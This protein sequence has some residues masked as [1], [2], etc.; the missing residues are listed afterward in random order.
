MAARVKLDFFWHSDLV[1]LTKKA[2][3]NL[4][5]L[6]EAK[7]LSQGKPPSV[8]VEFPDGKQARL[9]LSTQDCEDYF[10]R[11]T[12][13]TLL[14]QALG[15][16][17]DGTARFVYFPPETQPVESK[18][19]PPANLPAG[20]STKPPPPAAQS[21]GAASDRPPATQV[22]ADG[23]SFA[24]GQAKPPKAPVQT[25]EQLLKQELTSLLKQGNLMKAIIAVVLKRRYEIE[26]EWPT[27]KMSDA[28]FQGLCSTMFIKNLDHGSAHGFPHRYIDMTD[29]DNPPTHT[30]RTS[31]DE[32]V[33]GQGGVS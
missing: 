6:D 21:H 19:P 33:S 12:G 18:P 2:P 1:K 26:H 27:Y 17:R 8:P 20:A 11:Q 16:D 9:S 15:D 4:K 7:V 31:S 22:A 14:T 10:F 5:V 23:A 25:E 28:Q 13:Q 29:K 24:S 32:P 3:V 30:A